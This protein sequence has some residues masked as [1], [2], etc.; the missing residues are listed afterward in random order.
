MTA[1]IML[2]LKAY[3][4]D[5]ALILRSIHVHI[6]YASYSSRFQHVS[7]SAALF[8]FLSCGSNLGGHD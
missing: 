1:A 8:A 7:R 4:V 3:N 5:L 6:E 2:M